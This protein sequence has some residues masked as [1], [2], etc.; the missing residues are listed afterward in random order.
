LG[1]SSLRSMA[2]GSWAGSNV[3]ERAWTDRSRSGRLFTPRNPVQQ[4]MLEPYL[5]LDKLIKPGGNGAG[6]G[7][8]GSG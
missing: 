3:R 4:E 5:M 7:G 8:A 6:A 2:N 1:N